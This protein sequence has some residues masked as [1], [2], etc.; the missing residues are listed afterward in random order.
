MRD[1][2]D[3]STR[4]NCAPLGRVLT[5]G[6]VHAVNVVIL[7]VSSHHSAKIVFAKEQ[8]VVEALATAFE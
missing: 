4:P 1:G 8:N 6:Q 2:F 5:Q 3:R 7:D